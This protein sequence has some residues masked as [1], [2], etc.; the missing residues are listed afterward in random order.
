MRSG[1]WVAVVGVVVILLKESM[2]SRLQPAEASITRWVDAN[3][4][5]HSRMHTD[6]SSHSD[7]DIRIHVHNT[8]PARTSPPEGHSHTHL[9]PP[10]LLASLR[11]LF[12]LI[13]R[14][15]G[16]SKNTAWSSC[17]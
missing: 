13:S 6:T 9:S 17:Y 11:A 2:P 5:E 1:W 15:N 12:R 4:R 3:T 10:L 16:R 7:I 14:R 8:E